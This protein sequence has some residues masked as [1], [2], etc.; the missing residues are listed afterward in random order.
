[1][2]SWRASGKTRGF[3]LVELMIGVLLVA[4][5]LAVGAPGFQSLMANQRIRAATSDLRVA[6][7][8][9]R[10]EAVKRNRSV[11]LEPATGGWTKG[12]KIDNP[13]PALPAILNHSQSAAIEITGPASVAFRASGRV[14]GEQEFEV[15]TRVGS[16]TRYGCLVLQLDGRAVSQQGA[17][18]NG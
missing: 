18:P 14:T 5:L 3:T 10:S 7:M 8:T 1:M 6:L 2:N 9:A 15:A 13:D 11:S 16:D 4:I 12:W 17:C